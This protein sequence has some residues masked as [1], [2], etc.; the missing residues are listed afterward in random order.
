MLGVL[1]EHLRAAQERMKKF[2]VRKR[3]EVEFAVG[4]WVFLK[5]RPYRQVSVGS[6]RNEK[7][8]PKYFGPY[9]VEAKV[10]ALAYKLQLPA[11]ATIQL[12]KMVGQ[13]HV[14]SLNGLLSPPEVFGYRK[15]R[16]MGSLVGRAYPQTRLHESSLTIF[17][18]Q[19]PTFHLEDKVALEG[20]V[21]LGPNYSLHM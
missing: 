15:N 10:G 1:K 20:G 5:L 7:L 8:S 19:F 3:R 14:I 11:E 13:H 2:V 4:D 21:M 16:A 6:L 18:K 17:K 9:R 12:K